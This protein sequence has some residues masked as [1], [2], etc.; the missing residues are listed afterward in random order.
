MGARARRVALAETLEHVRQEF[1]T[2]PGAGVLH[3][4]V[5]V[6]GRAAQVHAD[7]PAA[8]RELDGVRDQVPYDLLQPIGVAGDPRRPGQRGLEPDLLGRGGRAQRV[9]RL[10]DDRAQLDGPDLEPQLAHHDARDVE[11]VPHDLRLGLRV[12]VDDVDGARPLTFVELA[13]LQEVGPAHDR[14]ERRAQLVRE[15]GQELVLGPVGRLRVAPRRPL[16]LQEELPFLLDPD[17][18]DELA[19]LAAHAEEGAEHL[20]IGLSLLGAEELEDAEAL[21]PERDGD[22]ER[23]AQARFQ[24]GRLS[25]E[26][27]VLLEVGDPG[28]FERGPDAPGQ[29]EAG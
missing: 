13:R 3:H 15:R 5:H 11:H 6:A 10:F 2:D 14:V 20:R 29:S 26:V 18:L 17:A 27:V 28:P 25:R 8:G 12:A 7:P 1:G 19:E 16:A 21:A 22:G 23:A 24:R 4:D 9:E